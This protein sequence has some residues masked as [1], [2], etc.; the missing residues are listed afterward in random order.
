MSQATASPSPVSVSQARRA[1]FDKEMAAFSRV[2]DTLRDD[3]GFN[4]F[5]IH[6]V[7]EAIRDAGMDLVLRQG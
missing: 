3:Y 1:E 5:Q 2:N 7:H 4:A 6:A